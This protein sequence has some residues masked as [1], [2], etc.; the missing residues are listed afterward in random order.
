[1]LKKNYIISKT[2]GMG[3]KSNCIQFMN[4]EKITLAL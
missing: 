1:M 3:R 4:E 2:P